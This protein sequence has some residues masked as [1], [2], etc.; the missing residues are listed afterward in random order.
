MNDV[1]LSPIVCI[2]QNSLG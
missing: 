1:L 2:T